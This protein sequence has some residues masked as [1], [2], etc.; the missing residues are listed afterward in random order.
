MIKKIIIEISN[1]EYTLTI[2]EAKAFYNGLKEIFDKEKIIEKEYYPYLKPNR[3]WWENP[4]LTYK[5]GDIR[6]SFNEVKK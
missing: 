4:I 3:P 1:K 5:T 6:C 2:D